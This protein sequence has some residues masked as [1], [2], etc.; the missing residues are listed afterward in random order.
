MRSG[1]LLE[2]RG[3]KLHEDCYLHS[4]LGWFAGG[5]QGHIGRDEGKLEG[6]DGKRRVF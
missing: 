4:F 2:E 3:K 1:D 6:K 5:N